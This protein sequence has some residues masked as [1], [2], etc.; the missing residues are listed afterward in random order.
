MD[1][2][3]WERRYRSGER[4]AED[5]EFAPAPLVMETAEKLQAGRALDLAC[6][7]GRNALWLAQR[8]WSVTAV[9]GAPAAI[10]VLRRRASER[11]V[12]VDARV[13]DLEKHEYQIEDSAWD[14]ILMSYYLQRDL[15]EP[16]K[17]G[18]VP[19]G[20][21][22]AIVHVTE[23]GEKPTATRLG[24]GALRSYFRGWEILHSHEGKSHD[25]AHR[26]AVAEIVARRP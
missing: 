24:R 19:G 21:V 5:F 15:F 10:E 20:V 16:A 2:H 8:G 9:D 22:I 1:L 3:G 18:V 14:L 13:A 7:T 25:P 23:A 11:G 17:R 26:R 6:G 4:A 12:G